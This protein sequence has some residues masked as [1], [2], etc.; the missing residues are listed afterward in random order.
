MPTFDDL[1]NSFENGNLEEF[2]SLASKLDSL[3]MLQDDVPLPVYLT[4]I[5]AD[6]TTPGKEEIFKFL[7]ENG[8]KLDVEDD[9]GRTPLS[10]LAFENN[11]HYFKFLIDLGA[12]INYS[13][14]GQSP[15]QRAI[16][17]NYSIDVARFIF[18]HPNYIPV[19]KGILSET[20]K[21]SGAKNSIALLKEL[22]IK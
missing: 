1:D 3:N 6:D 4:R 5:M 20:A 13:G 18:S 7:V 16:R 14:S 17:S 2:S 19:E 10:N 22:N 9:Q 11:L 21:S 12:D 8:T 15:I